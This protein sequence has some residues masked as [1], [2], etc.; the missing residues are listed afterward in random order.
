MTKEE[1]QSLAKAQVDQLGS[2]Y[3]KACI[4]EAEFARN[5]TLE[6][7]DSYIATKKLH[8]SVIANS[9][10]QAEI[11]NAR[12]EFKQARDAFIESYEVSLE[13][14]KKASEVLTS[15]GSTA[16]AGRN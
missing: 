14:E 15:Q 11:V 6:A 3:I 9:R 1:L 12:E 8:D 5:I 7:Q 16:L 13:V 4:D 10:S 2:D